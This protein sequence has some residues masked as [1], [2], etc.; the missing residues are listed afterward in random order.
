MCHKIWLVLRVLRFLD[1]MIDVGGKCSY[2]EKVL[3]IVLQ[4]WVKKTSH[5]KINTPGTDDEDI[6]SL[7]VM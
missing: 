2:T 4:K 3:H 5:Q 1:V 6:S 7:A